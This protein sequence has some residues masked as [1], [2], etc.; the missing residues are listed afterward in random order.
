MQ[1]P[2]EESTIHTGRVTFYKTGPFAGKII[3]SELVEIQQADLGRKFVDSFVPD[4]W[5]IHQNE[6]RYGRVDRRPIDPP[7]VVQ[8]R[9]FKVSGTYPQFET[10]VENY[11]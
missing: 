2:N 7:P 1:F 4:I 8:L 10:E 6:L 9:I 5:S 11:M 3:R